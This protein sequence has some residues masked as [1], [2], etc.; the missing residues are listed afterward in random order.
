LNARSQVPIVEGARVWSNSSGIAPARSSAM[1]S[2]ES[3]PASIDPTTESA[4]VPPFAP[5]SD[6]RTRAST[7]SASPT[8]WASAAAGNRPAADTKFASS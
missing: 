2:M 6:R 7:S 8:F 5:C 4:L 3:P 1:S